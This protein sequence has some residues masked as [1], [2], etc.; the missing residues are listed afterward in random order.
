LFLPSL[1]ERYLIDF[2]I[3]AF[4]LSTRDVTYGENRLSHKPTQG[5]ERKHSHGACLAAHS[6]VLTAPGVWLKCSAMK[7]F[8]MKLKNKK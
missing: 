4:L 8:L 6:E 3:F 1:F 5:S 7:L 2:H